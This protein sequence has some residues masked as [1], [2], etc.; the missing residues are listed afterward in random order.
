MAC[1][2]LIRRVFSSS[3]SPVPALVF[4][5]L[6]LVAGVV[7]SIAALTSPG[8]DSFVQRTI[9]TIH[10]EEMLSFE[11]PTGALGFWTTE[12]KY[13]RIPV[14]VT[15]FVLLAALTYCSAKQA[16]SSRNFTSFSSAT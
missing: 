7:L 12:L 2:S 6:L 13:Y 4:A 15:F 9:G 14:I 3:R 11:A 16:G 5:S 1:P 8:Q 10:L